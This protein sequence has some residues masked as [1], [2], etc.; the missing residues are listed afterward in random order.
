MRVVEAVETLT[1]VG[2]FLITNVAEN[3]RDFSQL[4]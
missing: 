2:K 3:I 1:V 4:L